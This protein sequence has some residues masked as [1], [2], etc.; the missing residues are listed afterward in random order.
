MLVKRGT[1]IDIPCLINEETIKNYLA[2]EITL[3]QKISLIINESDPGLC[4]ILGPLY[5][6][7]CIR[8]FLLIN[9][10]F[11]SLYRSKNQKIVKVLAPLIPTPPRKEVWK[12][13][14]MED[15]KKLFDILKLYDKCS[16]HVCELDKLDEECQHF[17]K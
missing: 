14:W 15:Y 11:G 10:P 16:I 9:Y 1:F 4:Q 7:L 12:Y 2:L 6:K 5:L 3:H 13:D 8:K 17:I